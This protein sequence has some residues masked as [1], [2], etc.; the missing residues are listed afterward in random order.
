MMRGDQLTV[1]HLLSFFSARGHAVDFYTLDTDGILSKAEEEWLRAHCETVRIYPQTWFTKLIG[2]FRSLVRAMPLQ[3]GMFWNRQLTRD[4]R[5]QIASDRYDIVYAYYLRSAPAVPERLGKG[6]TSFL[7]MQL[8]QTLNTERL[9]LN[10]RRFWKRVVYKIECRLL[11][12][13]EAS[14]WRNFTRVVLIGAKDVEAIQAACRAKGSPE[15]NNWVYGAHGTD[16]SKFLPAEPE[17]VIEDRVV[18]SGSMLYAPNVQAVLWFV[19]ECW[20]KIRAMRPR[21]E[22]IIQGRDP[23]SEVLRLNGRDG[24]VVT[25]TVS[26]VGF[27]IRSAAVCIAPIRAAG[28]MQNKV[29]EYMASAK[30]VVATSIANEGIMAPSNTLS[31]ADT[32]EDFADEVI[33]LL[34]DN[35]GA[36]LLGQRARAHVLAHWTWEA[37][38][39]KLEENMYAALDGKSV[40]DGDSPRL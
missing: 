39:L 9:L 32:A 15:M 2:I 6:T 38:F 3:V 1:A 37:H 31:I 18:F 33:S 27:Y 11:A 8:S 23:L 4:V 28:G 34:A 24:I 10:E 13:Y 35:A 36:Q 12:N 30:A 25:G 17:D 26:D 5:K 7:A 19:S 16:T 14:I 22:L 40:L 21:A 20:P 29:I